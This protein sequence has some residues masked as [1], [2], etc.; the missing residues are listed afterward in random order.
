MK[1]RSIHP[2]RRTLL[3]WA[4]A[5]TVGLVSLLGSNSANAQST[6]T[7][8]VLNV[9]Y[10]GMTTTGGT[11]YIPYVLTSGSAVTGLGSS[12]NVAFTWTA[13]S[14]S[15]DLWTTTP[16]TDTGRFGFTPDKT[17][18]F[19]GLPT[20]NTTSETAAGGIFDAIGGLIGN[21][22]IDVLGT[23]SI[24]AA[25]A[26]FAAGY[27]IIDDQ[28]SYRGN[29]SGAFVGSTYFSA[30]WASP[31]EGTIQTTKTHGQT[32]F[33]QYTAFSDGSPGNEGTVPLLRMGNVTGGSITYMP[34][35]EPSGLILIGAVGVLVVLRRE[36]K[37]Q[38]K[39]A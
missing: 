27:S 39:N 4:A 17:S 2:L 37:S 30:Y 24:A 33:F 8:D 25:A 29:A 20:N 38:T 34:V 11:V 31:V 36:R 9:N 18:L 35:P 28:V 6:Y 10:S 13:L 16:L 32:G 5:L 7:M 26:P 22:S 3:C 21:G 14:G 19:T 23:F 1:T 15:G 12:F